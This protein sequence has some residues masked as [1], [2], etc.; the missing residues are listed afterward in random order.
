MK[1]VTSITD[2]GAGLSCSVGVSAPVAVGIGMRRATGTAPSFE[3]IARL[4]HAFGA[5]PV[6]GSDVPVPGSDVP[7]TVDDA[8]AKKSKKHVPHPLPERSP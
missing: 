8:K 5:T 2:Q 6:P 7:V 1:T 3:L 4:R